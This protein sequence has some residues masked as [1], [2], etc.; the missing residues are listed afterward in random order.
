MHLD[1]NQVRCVDRALGDTPLDQRV[2]ALVA[3]LVSRRTEGVRATIS[4]LALVSAMGSF[5]TFEERVI[6]SEICRDTAD[7]L[8]REVERV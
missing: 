8:E 5:L 3:G 4:L 6:L 7:E 2:S 1:D